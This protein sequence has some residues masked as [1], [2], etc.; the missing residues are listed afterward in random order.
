MPNVKVGFM[1]AKTR[2]IGFFAAM[3][4]CTN[5]AA[6]IRACTIFVLTDTS[7]NQALFCNNEDFSNPK[8]RI[9]FLPAG[10]GYHGAAYVGYDNGWPQGGLNTEGLAFDWVAGYQAK[11]DRHSD[12]TSVRGNSSQRM[13]E[14]CV[15]VA[16]AIA[17][18]RNH[19]ESAFSYSQILVAD[20]SGASVI[21]GA[22]DWKLQV[23]PEAHCRGFGY[24]Q[25]TLDKML[26][27]H[28]E[29]TEVNGFKILQACCQKGQY[30]TKYSNIYD[31]KSG[32]IFLYPFPPRD[33]EV[34]LNLAVELKKG[35][36]YYDMR[37]IHEQ[38]A[39]DPRPLLPNMEPHFLDKFKPTPPL[40]NVHPIADT[41]PQVTAHFRAMIQGLRDGAMRA[42]DY[43]AQ[44]WDENSPHQ[45]QVQAALNAFGNL[46]SVTLVDRG[47]ADGQQSYRYQAEF[48]NGKFLIHF[49][50]NRQNK[51]TLIH[52]ED[53]EW[54]PDGATAAGQIQSDPSSGQVHA[55]PGHNNR[56]D[57]AAP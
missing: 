11:W 38:L 40:D 41:E 43:T 35:G 21:I 47:D 9:W 45:K 22:K 26:A 48:Q 57:V 27:T 20:K 34:R 44:T 31:M 24:G 39:R 36:H 49:V 1:N 37:K 29:P 50:L 12:L 13:L 30:A 54:K 3:L 56:S 51:C 32:D 6:P 7:H 23:E 19:H 53:S 25:E 52:F 33:D 10:D 5:P 15:T 46:I 17:F 42:D 28:C 8:T 14:T 2:L 55:D 4:L 18:Y 16:D